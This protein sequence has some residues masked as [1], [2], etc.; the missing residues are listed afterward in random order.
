[1]KNALDLFTNPSVSCGMGLAARFTSFRLELN[2]A[3]PLRITTT[4]GLK[5][6]IQFGIGM[7][8]M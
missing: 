3:L 4:D 7:H 8:F 1:M 5:P 2:M 6:G